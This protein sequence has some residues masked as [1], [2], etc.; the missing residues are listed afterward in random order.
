MRQ[1]IILISISM[2]LLV[3]TGCQSGNNMEVIIDG[4]GGFPEFLVGT[5]KMKGR[6]WEIVF[7][8]DGSIS[9]VVHYI[10]PVTLHPGQTTIVPT[11]EGGK[12]IFKAGQWSVQYTQGG[13]LAVSISLEHYHLEMYSDIVEGSSLDILIGPVSEELKTWTPI[14][15]TYPQYTAFTKDYPEG[16][17][18][19]TDD[20]SII[21]KGVRIFTKVESKD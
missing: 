21:N 20:P 16:K 1:L 2:A 8:P 14:W 7:E 11:L 15:S 9:S 10:V 4:D 18:L 13:E 19:P 12:G 3:S 5:W 6:H 17:V